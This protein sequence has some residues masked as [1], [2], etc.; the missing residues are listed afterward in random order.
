MRPQNIN[1][2]IRPDIPDIR[3]DIP[4]G[5]EI[6]PERPILSQE[7]PMDGPYNQNFQNFQFRPNTDSRPELANVLPNPGPMFYQR[8]T[9]N[10]RFP[11]MREIINTNQMPQVTIRQPM[12]MPMPVKEPEVRMLPVPLPPNLPPGKKVLINPHFKGNFQPPVEGKILNVTLTYISYSLNTY[13]L[14]TKT[15]DLSYKFILLMYI[16]TYI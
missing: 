4:M 13:A 12:P 6:S 3:P 15:T 7:L 1:P 9:Y 5:P 16:Y 11:P 2:Q 14:M 8:P 10:P